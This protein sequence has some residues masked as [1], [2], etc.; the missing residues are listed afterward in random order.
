MP[1]DEEEG[2]KGEE[3]REVDREEGG[4]PEGGLD[5]EGDAAGNCIK[6][7]LRKSCAN[8]IVECNYRL[9]ECCRFSNGLNIEDRKSFEQL[10]TFDK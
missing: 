10:I 9:L 2:V 3:D 7:M 1:G 4:D 6:P 8:C 5:V